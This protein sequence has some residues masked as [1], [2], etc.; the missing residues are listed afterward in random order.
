MECK[1]AIHAHVNTC[2]CPFMRRCITFESSYA[3][4]IFQF[5]FP[6]ATIV[7]VYPSATTVLV[8]I[9]RSVCD[10]RVCKYC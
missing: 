10:N 5:K 4:C 6:S 7:L 9:S 1:K 8:R 2:L 3:T